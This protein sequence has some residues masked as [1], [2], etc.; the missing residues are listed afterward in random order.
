MA[1]PAADTGARRGA[2]VL[3]HP[4]IDSDAHYLEV[5]PEFREQFIET[6]GELG[7]SRLRDELASAPNLRQYLLQRTTPVGQAFGSSRWRE[8]TPQERNDSCTPI[9]GWGPPHSNPLDMATAVLPSLRWER[10]EEIGIDF[11]VLYPSSALFYPHI[12][13]TELRQ[14]A[15]RAQNVINASAY[16]KYR[17]RMTPAALIPM[18]T[19]REAV[20]ELEFAVTELGLKVALI[21]HIARPI[22]AIH[23]SHPE[24]FQSAFRLD[25]F[26]L[27]SDH[28]YDPF[29]ARCAELKV[30]LVA[31]TSAYATGFRRSPSNYTFNHAGSFAEGGDLLCRSL[32]LGGVT[33]RFPDLKFQFLECGVGWACVLFAELVHRWEKRNITAVRQHVRAAEATRAEFLRLLSEHGGSEVRE[34]LGGLSDGVAAQIGTNDGIDDFAACGIEDVEDIWDLFVPRF[35]FGCEADDPITP[36][37]FDTRANPLGARLR[38]SLGSDMGHWDVPDM[39]RIVPEAHEMVDRGVLDEADFRRFVFEHPFEFFAGVNPGFF[40]GTKVDAFSP[41]PGRAAAVR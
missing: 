17:D 28:D 34:R 2:T 3:D 38:A 10:M 22:P 27:D 4:V 41:G 37:A 12:H 5:G 32:F 31:H 33:R 9:P 14:I 1:Q 20:S 29:W 25:T 13:P 40:A 23:R 21:G 16:R 8:Q 26:G 35:Y 6:A 30:P 11:S 19:P 18:D 36:F 7:G 39:R 24:L 15:C